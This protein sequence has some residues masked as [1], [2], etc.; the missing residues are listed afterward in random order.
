MAKSELCESRDKASARQF[1]APGTCCELSWTFACIIRVTRWQEILRSMGWVSELKLQRLSQQLADE[2]SVSAS[3]LSSGLVLVCRVSSQIPTT[4]ARYSVV[5][6]LQALTSW[7]EV[8]P[9]SVAG[10]GGEASYSGGACVRD[11]QLC[12]FA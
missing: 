6:L 10:G 5:L 4:A 3:M 11:C 2:L 9:P 12:W 7:G 1:C 8:E